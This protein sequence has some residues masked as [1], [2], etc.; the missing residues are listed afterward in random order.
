MS[1]LF[2]AFVIDKSDSNVQLEVQEIT[3]D[4]L[5]DAD[6]LIKVHYSGINYKDGLASQSNGKIVSTYPFIPGVDLAGQVVQSK[7][8]RFEKGDYVI[9]T[10]YDIGVSHYGGYSEYA[11]I[12]ADWI[13]PL[14]KSLSS[15]LTLK[16]SMILGTAGF[17]SAL[18]IQRLE[19]HGL[20]IDD[21][22]VVV[23]GATGGV[24]S[25]AVAMLA[26][27]GY[28]VIASTGKESEHDFLKSLGA[29]KVISREEL[30]DGTLKSLASQRWAAAI[31]PV[32]GK[33]LASL[34]SQIKSGGS[35]AVS[36]LTAGGSVPTTVYPFILRGVNLLGID[37]VFTPMS[38]RKQIW[39]RLSTDLKPNNIDSFIA[40]EIRLDDLPTTLPNILDG[41]IRGRVL[42]NVNS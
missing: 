6:V 25:L 9:A 31:D 38:V 42:I 1:E 4:F 3:K 2:K 33:P 20:S 5:P 41:N 10:S 24:G 18:S 15:G 11:S 22:P 23:T 37:S 16:E 14:P 17:T 34:L 8:R 39:H 19:E 29:S 7:D 21:G 36:G 12:P 30:Y 35:V 26:K 28:E 27:R 40:K 13:L 32:G